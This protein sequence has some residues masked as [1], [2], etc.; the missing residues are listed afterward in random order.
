[1]SWI[2]KRLE[3]KLNDLEDPSITNGKEFKTAKCRVMH[4]ETNNRNL[5]YKFGSSSLRMTEE[6]E[7]LYMLIRHKKSGWCDVSVKKARK[8]ISTEK[9]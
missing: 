2:R 8:D 5:C 1:M 7:N 3:Q 9:E 6:E 4:L